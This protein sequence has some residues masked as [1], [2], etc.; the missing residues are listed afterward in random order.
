MLVIGMITFLGLAVQARTVKED[1][2]AA[3]KAKK[4]VFMVV[5]N[6]TTNA[7][8]AIQIAQQAQKLLKG[9][10]VLTLNRDDKTNSETI[11]KLGLMSAPLPLIMVVGMNG[12]AAGGL[13][14]KE[15]T[16]DKLVKMAP[17]VRKAEALSY[18]DQK[19]PV[20]IVAYKKAFKDRSQ[21]VEN[22][23]SAIAS[24]KG[25]ADYVEV[26]LEDPAEKL[27]LEQVG[28]DVNSKATQILVFNAQGKNTENFS[29]ATDSKKLSTAALT[30]K[31]SGCA[32][33]SCAPGT[34]GCGK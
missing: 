17:S 30:V 2:D 33:G 27:F 22:C 8:K 18:I 10:M 6:A 32:P 31:K 1:L 12:L 15:A 3:K 9:S 5:T 7:E 4:T 11:T 14:E 29:G 20:F 21:V 23:K 16:A 19:K 25:N 13:Q 28:G 24:M 26:D 34:K